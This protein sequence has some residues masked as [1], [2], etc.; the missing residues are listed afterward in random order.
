MISRSKAAR[1]EPEELR[2]RAPHP[3]RH[4]PKFR[5]RAHGVLL[6]ARF[7]F[8]VAVV[9]L[10]ERLAEIDTASGEFGV[11]CTHKDCRAVHVLA[12]VA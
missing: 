3:A 6:P 1:V 11:S 8:P 5:D 12:R 4:K 7:P 2:C 9:R 10:A